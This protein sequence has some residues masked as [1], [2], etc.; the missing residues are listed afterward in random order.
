ISL[1]IS[2]VLDREN[3]QAMELYLSRR[4]S[5]MG[6]GV[7]LLLAVVQI[8][9]V[10]FAHLDEVDSRGHGEND[11]SNSLCG[12]GR[13]RRRRGG[14]ARA[15]GRHAQGGKGTRDGGAEHFGKGAEGTIGKV[16]LGS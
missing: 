10:V 14:R 7:Y 8:E 12:G 4:P 5:F 3:R 11:A 15:G 13:G 6:G 9:H 2:I 1:L 16:R